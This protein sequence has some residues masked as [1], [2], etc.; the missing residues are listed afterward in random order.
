MCESSWSE[1]SGFLT[2]E[3]HRT[4]NKQTM[5]YESETLREGPQPQ[6]GVSTHLQRLVLPL[7]RDFV[8]WTQMKPKRYLKKSLVAK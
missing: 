5:N 7:H 6:V 8:C 3:S 4:G 1:F 2:A